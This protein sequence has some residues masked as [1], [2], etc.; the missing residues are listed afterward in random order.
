[1]ATVTTIVKEMHSSLTPQWISKANFLSMFDRESSLVY[2]KGVPLFAGTGRQY[3]Y[4][5]VKGMIKTYAFEKDKEVLLDHYEVGDIF[6][7]QSLFSDVEGEA[8]AYPMGKSAIVKRI[9]A[10]SV[11]SILDQHT[12]LYFELLQQFNHSLIKNQQLPSM[13]ELIAG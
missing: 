12:H 2:K 13:D 9:A 6:N 5:V 11:K 7:F 1:M 8:M 3:I 10:K 4:L